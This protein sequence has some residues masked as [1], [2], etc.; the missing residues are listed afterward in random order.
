MS[1]IDTSVDI[2]GITFK[3]PFILASATPTMSAE[4]VK[5]GIDAGWGGA[6]LKT[7]FP[8]AHS[9]V[10]ARPRFKLWEFKNYPDYPR[11][12]P[13][14]FTI[15]VIEDA[16]VL[17]EEDYVKEIDRTKGMVGEEGVVIASIM[18]SDLE[19]WERYMEL[20]NGS[21]ADMTELNFGCPYAGEPGTKEEGPM[22]GWRLMEMGQEVVRLAKRKL[23][24]PFSPKISSQ[25]GDVSQWA[26]AFER[27]GAP[28]LTVAHRLSGV[29]IDIDSA[30]PYPF[31][32]MTGWGGPYLIGFGL[33]WVA[34][35]APRVKVPILGNMGVYDWEDVVRFIMVGAWA[36]ESAASV[37]VHGYDIVK[38]WNAK[39]RK[40][41]EEKGYS[42]LSEMR[43][44]AL[45]YIVPADKVERGTPGIYAVVDP[46]K[47]DGCQIC[48]RSCF[49]FAVD[50]VE[51]KA[52]VDYTK[53]DGCGLCAE[54]CPHDA[55]SIQKLAGLDLYPRSK[56]YHQYYAYRGPKT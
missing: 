50:I 24:I 43:G 46:S 17:N 34:K 8:A 7:L 39:L 44:R 27:D 33:K 6:V 4:N 42:T 26:V 28:A 36:V 48:Q 20:L 14:Y 9:R 2:C 52:Q 13:R 25:V 55:V 32:S 5:R 38:P 51:G 45:P 40:F 49:Y 11:R 3:N 41:M 12:T 35:T 47:C 22:L 53:C 15:S 23:S 21:K 16:S 18:A 19:S 1:S 29:W 37:I 54:L 10:V 31:G 30:K 56:P